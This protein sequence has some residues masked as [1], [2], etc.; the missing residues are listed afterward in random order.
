MNW[1]SLL[2]KY[3][4]AMIVTGFVAVAALTYSA[5]EWGRSKDRADEEPSDEMRAMP[6]SVRTIE[7]T[8]VKITDT[9]S[10]ILRPRERYSLGFQIAG[11]IVA[12]GVKQ[13][14]GE[15]AGVPPTGNP[16]QSW[17]GASAE[18][19]GSQVRPAVG[20]EYAPDRTV[21]DSRR[22]ADLAGRPLDVGDVV[23]PG[24]VLARLDQKI[25]EA[26]L[27][28]AQARLAQCK[29]E[30]SLARI[31]KDRASRAR[32]INLDSVSDPEWDQILTEESLK[33]SQI[34][35]AEAQLA[36]AEKNLA[37]T[38]LVVPEDARWATADPPHG[39]AAGRAGPADPGN[40]PPTAPNPGPPSAPLNPLPAQPTTSL[41]GTAD[42]CCVLVIS[43]R[44][45]NVGESVN[46]QQPIFEILQVDRLLLVVGVPEAYVRE[47]S[48]GQDVDVT[49]LAQD[50]FRNRPDPVSG[51]VYEVAEAA[52]QT[53][54][55]FEVEIEVP[56]RGLATLPDGRIKTLLKPGLI[57]RADII[58]NEM[59]AFPIPASA[60][61]FREDPDT[62]REQAFVFSI[63]EQDKAHPL[64][65]DKWIE[66]EIDGR[67]C[68]VVEHLP[69]QHRTIVT[70]G[71]HRLVEDCPVS[72][73]ER[74]GELVKTD[75]S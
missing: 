67:P 47:I 41:A 54:G 50:R 5:G 36:I 8:T 73:L 31:N 24:Q 55:L 72:I 10:G 40:P 22:G 33:G 4:G 70:R 17:E 52:D 35:M 32:E 62:G 59:K 30:F 38:T 44:L 11:R 45:A 19:P 29:A 3:V 21:A 1:K 20:L 27:S 64:R 15:G 51:K 57:A 25:Y 53:T 42:D 37:D 2:G 58:V 7:V 9:Y 65:L 23:Q 74:N 26:R 13:A 39:A 66:Q 14:A 49:L 60:V 12:F 16:G 69:P 43:E 68:V 6:V 61:L 56:N 28:E 75:S 71:Q 18:R 63:D 34:Q 46:P 48:P